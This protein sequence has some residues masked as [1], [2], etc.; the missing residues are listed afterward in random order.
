MMRWLIA[1]AMAAC[2]VYGCSQWT[3]EHRASTGP[4]ESYPVQTDTSEAAFAFKHLQLVP[5]A[6]YHV[7]AKLLSK[8]RY[9]W[10]DSAD[11]VPWDFAVGW[12][13]MSHEDVVAKLDISQSDRFY[14]YHWPHQPPIE[15]AL[16]VR[17]S[18]NMHLIPANSAVASQLDRARA[19]YKVVLDGKLVDA[20]WPDGRKWSTSLTRED[21]GR[22]ACELM[23]V[24]SVAVSHP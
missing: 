2:A 17:N 1:A 6:R 10:G 5:R 3:M 24:E 21:T 19:G 13:P 15:P 4:V 20:V 18:A 16:I 11:L 8:E 14:S 12:G 9:R 7:E 22:G 23:Y